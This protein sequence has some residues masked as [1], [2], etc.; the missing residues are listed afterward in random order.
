MSSV[1]DI[2]NQGLTQVGASRITDL[3]D[4]T[5]EADLA[6]TLYLNIKHSILRS[7]PWNCA[8]RRA[9]L[10]Q[11]TEDPINEWDHAYAWPPGCLRILQIYIGD[12]KARRM[13]SRE[14][15]A[16]QIE[17]KKVFT[18]EKNVYAKYIHDIDEEEL[19]V[20]VEMALIARFASEVCYAVQG[21]NTT[22][23]N[24]VGMAAQ[25]LDEAKT[26]DNLEQPHER[27]KID[28][29]NTVRR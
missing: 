7:Y 6:S 5:T 24:F 26:T 20:H 28:R 12:E 3:G 11:L 8:T 22:W 19:D 16:Y 13:K 14:D 1:I 9:K 10:A 25:K 21:Q 18:W 15:P 4:G 17:G 29:L 23:T 2:V 27:F